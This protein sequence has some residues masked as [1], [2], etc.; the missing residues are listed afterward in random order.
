MS[1]G[2]AWSSK[3]Q[4]QIDKEKELLE[5]TMRVNEAVELIDRV[6]WEIAELLE[7]RR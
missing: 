1:D 5:R 3:R 4:E 2:M 7:N 6:K